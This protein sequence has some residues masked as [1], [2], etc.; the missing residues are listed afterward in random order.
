MIS[1][2][3]VLTFFDAKLVSQDYGSLS[4]RIRALVKDRVVE[5]AMNID[6]GM[7][8]NESIMDCVFREMKTQFCGHI[9]SMR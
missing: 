1:E 3:R 5:Y 7:L 8:L 6:M 4:F 9:D 2:Y